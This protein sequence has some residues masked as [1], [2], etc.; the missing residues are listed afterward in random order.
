MA[1]LELAGP[2]DLRGTLDLVGQGG[3]VLVNGG[4][5]LVVGATGKGVPIFLPPQAPQ[6]TGPDVECVASLGSGITAAGATVVTT[7]MVLQGNP[8]TW[9]GMLTPSTTN[10]GPVQVTANVLPVNVVGDTA[11]VFPNGSTATFDGSG[12]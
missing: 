10:T 6:G 4:E 9:P 8:R 3:K 7:G 1:D 11:S 5:A 12:Q 2:L